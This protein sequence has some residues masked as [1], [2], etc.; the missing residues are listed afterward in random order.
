MTDKKL[1]VL[2]AE[3]AAGEVSA[4][5]R[6]LY[7]EAEGRLELTDVGSLSTLLPTILMTN[8]DVALV[9]LGLAKPDIVDTVRRVHRGAPQVPLVVIADR[10]EKQEAVRCLDAGAVDYLLKGFLDTRTV[11]RA[12]RT[13]VERNTLSALA[14][15][16]RDPLTDLY[17]RDG[18]LTLGGHAL[19][20]ARR[21]GG[22][23]VLLCA[24]IE[25]LMTIRQQLGN[26]GVE[27]TVRELAGLLSSSFRRTDV[28]ARLGD[29]QFA[30]LA[31]D[32]VEPSAQVLFQRVH[33]RVAA[34]NSL[35]D[36]STGT[37]LRLAVGFWSAKDAAKFGDLLDRVESQL[38]AGGLHDADQTTRPVGVTGG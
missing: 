27:Q 16:L 35:R 33:R 34:Q 24:R 13:A 12:L 2:V 17:T 29:D 37:Q 31:V 32:A 36:A 25:N 38:R 8:P 9:D 18:F 1:R 22:T 10:N 14:D 26:S 3:D 21:G 30:A 7:P 19:E 5:L 11:D 15:L 6:E 28:L 4:A 20:T 23:L